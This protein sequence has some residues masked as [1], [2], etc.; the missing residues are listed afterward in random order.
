VKFKNTERQYSRII[1]ITF[2]EKFSLS[3]TS[4]I[5]CIFHIFVIYNTIYSCSFYVCVCS[6]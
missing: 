2:C 1:R 6:R 5:L 4:E 3:A